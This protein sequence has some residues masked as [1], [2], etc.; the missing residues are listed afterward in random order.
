MGWVGVKG[1][2]DAGLKQMKVIS[3]KED[4]GRK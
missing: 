4:G 1:G 3:R 2:V